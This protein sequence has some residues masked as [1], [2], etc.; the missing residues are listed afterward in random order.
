MSSPQIGPD[1]LR[2][3][4]PDTSSDLSL[5][6]LE[7]PVEIIRDRRG[8]PHIR[9]S[10]VGDVFFAQGFATAQDRLWHM[11]YDRRRACGRWAELAGPTALDQDK[12][13]RRFRL[14]ASARADYQTI[15]GAARE[16]VDSYARGVNAFIDSADNLPVEYRIVGA[17]PEPWQ[18]LPT[19]DFLGIGL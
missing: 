15:G 2:A 4:L 14:E 13:M 1:D 5:Q 12:S 7:G 18:P 19:I 11:D 8:I 16:M 9:A 3:V 17:G 10:T 6:G